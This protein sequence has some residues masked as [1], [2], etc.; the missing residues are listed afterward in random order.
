MRKKR[1]NIEQQ[2]RASQINQEQQMQLVEMQKA[3]EEEKTK[4]EARVDLEVKQALAAQKLQGQ[5]ETKDK[6]KDNRIEEERASVELK[7]EK[8]EMY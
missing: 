1:Q 5:L 3:L 7:S 4:F 8:E 2:T 6:I